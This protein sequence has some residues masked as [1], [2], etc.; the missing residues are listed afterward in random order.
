M[1][2]SLRRT[3]TRKPAMYFRKP[4]APKE[5]YFVEI[6]DTF[7][8]DANY[9]WVRR[10]KVPAASMRQALTLA[11]HE[12][13]GY[14]PRHKTSDYGDM[15]RADFAGMCVCAFVQWFDEESHGMSNFKSL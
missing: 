13:F 3:T 15:V 6:T 2:C 8:G 1:R 9:S 5:F 11:K 10:F 14:M 7:G 12:Y 4:A